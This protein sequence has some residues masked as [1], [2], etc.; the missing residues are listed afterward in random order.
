MNVKKLVTV[1]TYFASYEDALSKLDVMIDIINHVL[2]GMGRTYLFVLMVYR[3]DLLM[4]PKLSPGTGN[5]S[6]E[7]TQ[8]QKDFLTRISS[9][10][11]KLISGITERFLYHIPNTK[12]I[13]RFTSHPLNC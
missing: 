2:L 12:V 10:I 4:S 5:N 11:F 8:K 9:L 7:I 6:Q 3:T 13:E 1:K